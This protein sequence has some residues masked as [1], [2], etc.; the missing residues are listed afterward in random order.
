[1]EKLVRKKKILIVK[2]KIPSVME[3]FGCCLSGVYNAL[4]Y[5][6]NS[7]LAKAIR[8]YVLQ[9]CGGQKVSVAQFEE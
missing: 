4:A 9:E 7:K 1:M 2:D 5:R 6:S 3:K 8:T